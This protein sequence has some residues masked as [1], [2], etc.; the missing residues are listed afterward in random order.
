M[1]THVPGARMLTALAALVLL[2]PA[3]AHAAGPRMFF[4]HH[5]TGRNML[6]YGNARTLLAQAS[7]EKSVEVSVGILNR[8]ESGID[9]SIK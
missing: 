6:D 3:L 8:H 4:L 9:S 5:S 2:L 1:R 7:V